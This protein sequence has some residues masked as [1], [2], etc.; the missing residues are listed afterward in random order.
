MKKV[1]RVKKNEDFQCILKNGQ[2]FANR[3]FVVY[4]IYEENRE[5][6]TFGISV[7]K[8]LGNAVLRNR[9][10]RKVRACI[11]NHQEEI[12]NN[13]KMIVIARN[14]CVNLAHTDFEKGLLH[15]LT[16]AKIIRRKESE[17]S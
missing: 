5:R 6:F 11:R 9:I 2:Y 16:N 8:K 17:K 3:Q 4:Y 7:G 1:F 10:K 15:V 14:S 12:S 13:I